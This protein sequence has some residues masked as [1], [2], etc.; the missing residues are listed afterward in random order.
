MGPMISVK[1][2]SVS[3]TKNYQSLK[4]VQDV[5]FQV[6]PGECYGIVGE[7]GSGK[8]TLLSALS[9]LSSDW[10]G[11]IIIDDISFEGPSKILLPRTQQMVFQDPYGTLHPR[12]TIDQIL[13]E[14]LEINNIKN[15][16]QKI[17]KV[18]DQVA[19]PYAFRFRYPHQLS[20]GERQRIAIARALMLAPKI[21]YLDEPTSALDASIQAEILNLF[22]QMQQEYNLT[23]ILVSHNMAL[24]A[25]MCSK[26]SVMYQGKFVETLTRDALRTKN[27]QHPYTQKLIQFA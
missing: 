2:L 3:Y 24:I 4:V 12:H 17:K 20:G 14:P 26:V 13:S 18:L 6:Q 9:G 23:Y 21:L 10:K 7:S 15:A 1:N 19:F 5:S 27:V 8:S 25:H 11:S 16:P 22:S